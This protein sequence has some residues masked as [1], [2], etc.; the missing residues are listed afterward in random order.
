MHSFLIKY[1]RAGFVCGGD[2]NKMETNLI[3]NALPKCRQIVTKFTYKNKQIHDVILTNMSA[4]Y[5]VPYVCPAVQVDVPGKGVPSDLIN[6]APD[7]LVC[8]CQ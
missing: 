1:P 5:A 2:R 3:E 4:L 6:L 7:Q 8:S